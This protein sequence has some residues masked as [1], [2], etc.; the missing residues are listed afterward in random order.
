[1]YLST[2]YS[3]DAYYNIGQ[4]GDHRLRLGFFP[5]LNQY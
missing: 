3:A 1:M 2:C 4:D 5:Q